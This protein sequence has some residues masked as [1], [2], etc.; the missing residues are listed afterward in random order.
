MTLGGKKRSMARVAVVASIVAISAAG[1]TTEHYVYENQ[2]Q[3]IQRELSTQTEAVNFQ[4]EEID[5]LQNELDAQLSENRR[6]KQEVTNLRGEISK[7]EARTIRVAV[8]A[9]DLSEPSCGKVPS[10]PDYGVTATGVRLAGCSRESAKA[11]AVDPNVIPLG[12]KVRLTFDEPSMQK[13][14][15]I[16][17]AVDTGGAIKGNRIDLFMGEGSHAECMDFGR[18]EAKLVLL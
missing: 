1:Y 13:Y 9:Y 4:T 15:G 8:T 11:I 3:V 16:Y 6:L 12:S 5:R 18:R 7:E 17:T 2:M 10:S 14:N